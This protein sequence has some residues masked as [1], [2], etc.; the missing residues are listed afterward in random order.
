[1]RFEVGRARLFMKLRV[2]TLK[3][4]EPIAAARMT[5]I[6]RDAW[7]LFVRE[8]GCRDSDLLLVAGRPGICD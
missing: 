4:N 8:T 7:T 1:M 5:M 3:E 6:A 2:E